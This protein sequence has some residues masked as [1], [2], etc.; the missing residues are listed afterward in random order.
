MISHAS[1]SSFFF[2]QERVEWGKK[3]ASLPSAIFPLERKP[4]CYVVDVG[5]KWLS[6]WMEKGP[7]PS[8]PLFNKSAERLLTPSPSR[9]RTII[10]TGHPCISKLWAA[11]GEL[12]GNSP[13]FVM[14]SQC[15]NT[16]IMGSFWRNNGCL[17]I[18]CTWKIFVFYYFFHLCS[19]SYQRIVNF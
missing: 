16:P 4:R 14:A 7:P 2:L 18:K 1:S 8:Q 5:T 13:L 11:P 6:N 19:V 3:K 9:D 12:R 17:V 15:Q 10:S